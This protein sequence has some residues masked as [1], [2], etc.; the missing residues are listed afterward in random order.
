MKKALAVVLSVLLVFSM[1]SMAVSAATVPIDSAVVKVEFVNYYGLQVGYVGYSSIKNAEA[2]DVPVVDK[3][4]EGTE[5][6]DGTTKEYRYTFTGWKCDCCGNVFYD[7]T[8][9]THDEVLGEIVLTA[10]YSKKD[11]SEN[12]T[13]WQF[14]QSIFARINIL[15]EYFATIFKF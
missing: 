13:F 15:F 9:A 12:Q 7:N 11:L 3:E 4:F 5:I 1:F 14:I 10:Q 2:A 8:I 6:V